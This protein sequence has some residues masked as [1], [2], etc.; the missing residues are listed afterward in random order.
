MDSVTTLS[1]PGI[2]QPVLVNGGSASS[3]SNATQVSSE[4]QSALSQ[5]SSM[6]SI[7]RQESRT[8]SSKTSIYREDSYGSSSEYHSRAW[9]TLAKCKLDLKLPGTLTI[10]PGSSGFEF[11]VTTFN[12]D[13]LVGNINWGACS[14]TSVHLEGTVLVA[15]CNPV[16]GEPV[17]SKLDLNEHIIYVNSRRC[18]EAIEADPDF[19]DLISSAGWMNV[20]VITQPDMRGFLTNPAFQST[21]KAAAQRAVEEVISEMR[22]EMSLAIEKAVTKVSAMSQEF[23]EIEMRTLTRKA[24]LTNSAAYSGLGHLK[25]MSH[26]QRHA[27]SLFAPHIGHGPT[28]YLAALKGMVTGHTAPAPVPEATPSRKANG[29]PGK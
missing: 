12:L 22:E 21:I 26:E 28:G 23:V 25:V 16:A 17:Q 19:I 4:Q 3:E 27:Y 1:K 9:L 14:C 15:L 18:W 7:Q 5:S 13:D 29:T 11:K 24:T 2:A 20:A 8:L 10:K 6:T